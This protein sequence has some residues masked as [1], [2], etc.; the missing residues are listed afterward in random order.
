MNDLV[1][2]M[3]IAAALSGTF[4]VALVPLVKRLAFRFKAVRAPRE[5]DVHTGIMPLWGGLA[6]IAGFMLT[7]L[8]MRFWQGH[9]MAVAVGKGEHPILGILL[10]ATIV[11]IVGLLDDKYDLKPAH[12]T[13]GMLLAGLVAALLGARIEGITNPFAF[14]IS[15]EDYTARNWI[16]LPYVASVVLTMAWTFVVTKTFDFLDGLDGMAAGVCAIAATTMGLMAAYT[17][18]Q[19]VTVAIMAA[20]LAG[21]CIGFLRYNYNPASI[22]MGTIG[23]YFLGFILAMLAIVG[24][25]KIPAAISVALPPLVLGVPI[26]DAFYVAFRRI[27]RGESPT[28]ADQTHIHH[29]LRRKGLSVQRA[30]WTVYGLTAVCCVAALIL[31]F[32]AGR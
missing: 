20:A 23:A 6:I 15:S 27:Q 4:A 12:Q 26:I 30:V 13:L 21:G 22:F 16:Q 7:V 1:L 5:R 2:K 29:R 11:G 14:P 19:D 8:I 18:R 9:D 3:L 24:A 32:V 25:F 10:G 31:T 28:K 17:G